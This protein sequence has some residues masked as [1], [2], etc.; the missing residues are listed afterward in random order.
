M[1]TLKNELLMVF[2]TLIVIG[3]QYFYPVVIATESM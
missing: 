3:I 2:L 1:R